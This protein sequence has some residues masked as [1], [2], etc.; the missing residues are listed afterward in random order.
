MEILN[1]PHKAF[2]KSD[3]QVLIACPECN[4][5]KVFSAEQFRDRQ[6]LLKIKCRCGHYF[7]VQLEFRLH[8]RRKTELEG[9]CKF[10]TTGGWKVKLINLSLGGV[11][12]EILGNHRIVVGERGKLEFILDDRKLT[13]IKKKV[14]VKGVTANLIRCE[15]I[16]DRAYQ[17]ELGFYLRP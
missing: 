1:T 9:F 12:L 4:F 13:V 11:C 7:T 5:S 3:D 16:E 8:I 2:V 6:H 10:E 14:I 15:F 17:K